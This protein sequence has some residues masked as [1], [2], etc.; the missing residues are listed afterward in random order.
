MG[1]TFLDEFG[2]HRS[3]ELSRQL[4]SCQEL[5][6]KLGGFPKS[7]HVIAGNTENEHDTYTAVR[8][9]GPA[10]HLAHTYVYIYNIH[11]QLHIRS[12]WL[13]PSK[14]NPSPPQLPRRLIVPAAAF[15]ATAF[16]AVAIA[17]TI[18]WVDGVARLTIWEACFS[19]E[20]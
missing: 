15:A 3:D 8:G 10:A 11:I 4:N 13:P 17:L 9:Q 20:H 12:T 14:S 5:H 16:A 19:T 2:V 18:A 7:A 1:T 6:M